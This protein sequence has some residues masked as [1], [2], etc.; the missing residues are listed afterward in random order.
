MSFADLPSHMRGR[1]E[2]VFGYGRPIPL[3]RNA[4]ARIMVLAR[5]MSRRTEPGK[6]Y[7]ILTAKFLAVLGALLWGFHNTKDGRCFPS[8]EAIA[9][10]AD[11]HR[12]TV[13]EA[14]KA[15]ERAGILSWVNRLI[16]VREGVKDL[17]GRAT[18]RVR[19]LRT[20]NAYTFRDPGEGTRPPPVACGIRSKPSKSENTAGTPSQV[21]RK[22]ESL[23]AKGA[24]GWFG[25]PRIDP[26]DRAEALAKLRAE[27]GDVID[28]I[29]DAPTCRR[30]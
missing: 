13:Y 1:R 29:P 22:E 3:D 7:G 12:D 24:G 5:A 15:L 23:P 17:F 6:A 2:K 4:K 30:S 18:G 25:L 20:S 10:R 21:F 9:E 8:Y 26:N 14:I 11:C 16:R 19:V 28:S 27:L